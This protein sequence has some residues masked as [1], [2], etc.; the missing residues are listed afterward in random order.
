[1]K[2]KFLANKKSDKK[3]FYKKRKR[4]REFRKIKISGDKNFEG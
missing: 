1:M 2:R 3:E 4:K